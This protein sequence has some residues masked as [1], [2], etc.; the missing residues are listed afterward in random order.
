MDQTDRCWLELVDD[1][2]VYVFTTEE[3]QAHFLR[4]QAAPLLPDLRRIYEGTT[5]SA[6]EE[7]E[8]IP[9]EEQD[10]DRHIEVAQSQGLIG[11]KKTSTLD[12]LYGV[13]TQKLSNRRR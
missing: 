8:D 6:H 7:E 4:P 2:L 12:Q 13:Q 10:S 11:I 9:D 1:K 5:E 3:L